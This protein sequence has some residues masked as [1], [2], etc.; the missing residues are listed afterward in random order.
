MQQGLMHRI[1]L[2]FSPHYMKVSVG[3][4]ESI[5]ACGFDDQCAQYHQSGIGLWAKLGISQV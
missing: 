1:L 4:I 3:G 5:P 2:E